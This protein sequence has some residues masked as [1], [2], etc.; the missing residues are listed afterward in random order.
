M[1]AIHTCQFKN[2]NIDDL[3]ISPPDKLNRSVKISEAC[4]EPI[5]NEKSSNDSALKRLAAIQASSLYYYDITTSQTISTQ[6]VL[7]YVTNSLRIKLYKD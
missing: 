1:E 6:L 5:A 4:F 7:S 3:P 2:S